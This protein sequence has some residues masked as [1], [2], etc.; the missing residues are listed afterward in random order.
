MHQN[1]MNE[2]TQ[3]FK[4]TLSAWL[5]MRIWGGGPYVFHLL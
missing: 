1:S 4:E 2:I 5:L 3:S